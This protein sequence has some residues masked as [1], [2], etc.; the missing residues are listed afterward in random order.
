MTATSYG[1]LPQGSI[2][3]KNESVLEYKKGKILVEK[4]DELAKFY[5]ENYF[6][7]FKEKKNSFV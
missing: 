4:Q 2:K 7:K 3:V 1:S 5:L 6:K